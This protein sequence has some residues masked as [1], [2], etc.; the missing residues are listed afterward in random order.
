MPNQ[1]DFSKPNLDGIPVPTLVERF[2]AGDSLAKLCIDYH[3]TTY[4][5]Q[6]VLRHALGVYVRKLGIGVLRE[7]EGP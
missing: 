1:P 2:L 6:V 5:I 7:A 4:G 3:L